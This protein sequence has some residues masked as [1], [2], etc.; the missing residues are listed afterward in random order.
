MRGLTSASLPSFS[1]AALFLDMDGTL[2]DIAPT[3]DAVVVPPDLIASLCLLRDR[4]DG[5]L[6]IVTG[7]PI[8]EVDALLKSA[9]YAIA[10]EHGSTLRNAPG[11]EETHLALPIPPSEWLSAA[12]AIAARHPG[13]MVERKSRGFVLHYRA[14][15]AHGPSLQ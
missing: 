10:G 3:P 1:R 13:T 4:L 12:E 8:A 2:L 7:R 15:P 11:A 9:P 14:A 5:A 6:A